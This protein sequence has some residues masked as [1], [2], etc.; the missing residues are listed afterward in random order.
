MS[1]DR[2]PGL[3]DYDPDV[4]AP[5]LPREE[6]APGVARVRR[7][8]RTQLERRPSDLDA[9]LPAGHRAR[10]VWAW[11][12]QADLSRMYA[13]LRAVAGGSGRT[14]I[15]PEILFARWL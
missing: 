5:D 6:P 10:V 14:A 12:E 13:G 8:N 9:L 1:D 11:V 15:A 2:Q 4:P 3:F 7:P